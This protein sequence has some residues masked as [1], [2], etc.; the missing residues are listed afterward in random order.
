M[1]NTEVF[2]PSGVTGGGVAL[3]G[4]KGNTW[5]KCSPRE[6]RSSRTPLVVSTQYVERCVEDGSEVEQPNEWAAAAVVSRG[7]ADMRVRTTASCRP[8][9]GCEA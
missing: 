4:K 2:L 7:T 1:I 9:R 8:R 5:A 6:R 3:G